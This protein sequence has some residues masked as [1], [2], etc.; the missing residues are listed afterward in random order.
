MRM[1]V[2]LLCFAFMMAGS[3]QAAIKDSSP[4][5]ALR[6]YLKKD[7]TQRP[8]LAEQPFTQQPLSKEEAQSAA[9]LL[10]DAWTKQIVSERKDM[11]D[12][13]VVY[14]GTGKLRIDMPL[15]YRVFGEPVNGMRSLYISLHGG[16]STSVESNDQ[17]WVN[18]KRLYQLEEGIYLAPRAPGNCWN[19]WHR[20]HV[21]PLLDLVIEN[22]IV[23]EKVD[24]NRVYLTG[25][26]A[27]GDGVY[28]LAPRMAD[29]FAAAAM[30]AGHPNDAKPHG[31][32]NIGFTIQMGGQDSAYNRNMVA[33]QW[34]EWLDEL[35]AA[36][37]AGYEH[38]VQIYP[39]YGHWMNGADR[40]ALRWMAQFTRDPYPTRVVWK[41]DDVIHTRFYWLG[42]KEAECFPGGTVV[43]SYA[44]QEI[45]IERCAVRRLRIRLHDQMM[46]LD[47]PIR[48]TRGDDV[49][50]EGI[51]PRTIEA[52]AT[53][54]AE[55]GDPR[56][57][58][59]A[60]VWVPSNPGVTKLNL[61]VSGG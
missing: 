37:P 8:A 30:M 53:S 29:R 1:S 11:M 20:L 40:I 55:R 15:Y 57:L 46:D 43:A 5:E 27:G 58:C 9:A 4:I 52:I 23:F 50:F 56:S 47:R 31:L 14:I 13:R 19:M 60:E 35:K 28:Q 10:W 39:E 22:M 48:I 34:G 21:D 16:G 49:I 6:E 61:D 24:P 59:F 54:L 44:G 26:S 12:E 51:V 3:V 25:Y 36:D 32:R 33:A 45:R 7:A 38:W 18:Q 41:Q 42:A 17:Q 2:M